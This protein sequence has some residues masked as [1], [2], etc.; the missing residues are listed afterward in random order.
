MCAQNHSLLSAVAQD[1]KGEASDDTAG[2]QPFCGRVS[3][4]DEGTL[5]VGHPNRRLVS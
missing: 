1:K 3:P 4:S 2:I 5:L